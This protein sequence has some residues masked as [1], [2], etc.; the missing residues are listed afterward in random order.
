[1]GCHGRECKTLS[2][3]Q[4]KWLQ[5]LQNNSLKKGWRYEQ[6]AAPYTA[7]GRC[8]DSVAKEDPRESGKAPT[9]SLQIP[10][11]VKGSHNEMT[12]SVA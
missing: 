11:S 3:L 2:F 10:K 8:K 7:V 6:L 12:V 9:A 4:A 5:S 1:M